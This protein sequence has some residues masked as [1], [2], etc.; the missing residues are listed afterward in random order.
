MTVD[1]KGEVRRLLLFAVVA[2]LIVLII[3]ALNFWMEIF[4]IRSVPPNYCQYG[5]ING[6]GVVSKADY[7][8]IPFTWYQKER[9]D[10]DND[11]DVDSFD[12]QLINYYIEGMLD[13][14]PIAD[15]FSPSWQMD[16]RPIFKSFSASREN[17]R[18]GEEVTFIA[19][20]N[21]SNGETLKAFIVIYMNDIPIKQ[22]VGEKLEPSLSYVRS[23]K[24]NSSGTYTA[25]AFVSYAYRSA[26]WWESIPITI[27]V[28]EPQR[29]VAN[30]TYFVDGLTVDFYDNSFDLDGYIVNYTWNFGDGSI[31]YGKTVEHEYN[32]SGEYD[33]TLT[34]TDDDGLT[35]SKTVTISVSRG[36]IYLLLLAGLIPAVAGVIYLK[37]KRRRRK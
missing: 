7:Y 6:D 23:Y 24:F 1:Y 2:I 29:P 31:A 32:T 33:V 34:V 8:A 11:G 15:M 22:F 18:V 21:D 3:F 30:F 36:N 35:S 12:K 9:G 16:K 4:G 26:I 5:D 17:V 13:Q 37:K 14:F 10:V 27:T 20:A 19:I 25:K 28:S